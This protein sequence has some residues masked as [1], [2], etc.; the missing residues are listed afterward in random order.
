LATRQVTTDVPADERVR[1]R[2]SV[3]LQAGKTVTAVVP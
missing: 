2:R 3:S 1:I